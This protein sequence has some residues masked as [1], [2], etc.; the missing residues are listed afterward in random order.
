MRIIVFLFFALTH[1]AI[2]AQKDRVNATLVLKNT[3]TIRG[4]INRSDLNNLQKTIYLYLPGGTNS[5]S[6]YEFLSIDKI[7]INEKE[8]FYLWDGVLDLSYIDKYLLEAKNEGETRRDTIW[9]ETLYKGSVVSLLGYKTETKT[10]FFIKENKTIEALLIH[11]E[12]VD[13][14]YA[15]WGPTGRTPKYKIY[16]YYQN[17]LYRFFDWL[18]YKKLTNQINAADYNEKSLKK[19]LGNIN[20]I[21]SGTNL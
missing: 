18:R 17:Q 21:R 16:P 7:V 13:H 3:D 11:Y 5:F 12:N 19:V 1:S 6:V 20:S 15:Q 4:L 14:F 2:F 9:L 10:H 8:E